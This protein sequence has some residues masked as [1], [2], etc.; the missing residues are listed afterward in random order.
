[1]VKGICAKKEPGGAE[2]SRA[3]PRRS[4]PQSLSRSCWGLACDQLSCTLPTHPN[5]LVLI[6][7][8]QTPMSLSFSPAEMESLFGWVGRAG[9]PQSHSGTALGAS[10]RS[11]GPL[12]QWI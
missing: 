5:P 6:L 10:D 12:R 4:Q 9:W 8:S 2:G 1:M 3:G 11:E 7:H